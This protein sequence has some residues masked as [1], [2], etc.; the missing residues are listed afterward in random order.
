VQTIDALGRNFFDLFSLPARFELDA[1]MQAG[2]AQA[3]DALAAATEA[4]AAR[5]MDRSIAQA[6]TGR[7]LDEIGR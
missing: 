7:R 4:F 3:L 2:D 5:R 6:L 1:A